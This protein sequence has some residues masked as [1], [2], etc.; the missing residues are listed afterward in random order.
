[1]RPCRQ[2]VESTDFVTYLDYYYNDAPQH[3]CNKRDCDPAQNL[4]KK[5][6]ADFGSLFFARIYLIKCVSAAEDISA[7]EYCVIYSP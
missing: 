3:K 6:T 2:Q 7:H 5:K 1:M 4:R